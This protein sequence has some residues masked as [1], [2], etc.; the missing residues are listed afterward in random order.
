VTD[1]TAERRPAFHG[2][3]DTL[4]GI[5]LINLLLSLVTL[6]IYQFW[7]RT[8]VRQYVWGATELDGER[9]VYH[10]TGR[11]LLIGWLKAV[12]V[13][14]GLW[15]LLVAGATS[16]ESEYAAALM[17][18]YAAMLVLVPLA[19]IGARRY[20]L[21]RT[22]W[23]GIRFA[24]RGNT[25]AFIRLWA[26]GALL[27]GLTFSLYRP[28]F[29]T[30]TRAY[31]TGHMTFGSGRFGYDGEGGDLFGR[32]V[33]AL[34]LTIPTL[35][36]IWFWYHAF[37]TRYDAEHTTFEGARFASEVTAGGLLG[38]GVTNLLL[39]V[40]TLGIG[41]PWALVRYRRYLT[42]C[43]SLNGWVDFDAV[44][45]QSAPQASAAEGFAE[46]LDVGG[47]DIGL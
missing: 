30:K 15:A 45:Q 40:F 11:E 12:V 39:V 44:I 23:R 16:G 43:L 26:T 32:Y 13:F 14:G 41:L 1:T 9:F 6:G 37:R 8:R 47:F 36:L 17:L 33:S 10:G 35:G 4:L 31:L 27:T 21:S 25:G 38:L 46:M 3:G 19:I 29:E 42:D 5:Y 7:G 24:Q 28:H 34:L 2:T 22:T 18:F 20:R